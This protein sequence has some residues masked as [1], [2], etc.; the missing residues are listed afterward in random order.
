VLTP[1]GWDSAGD[2]YEIDAVAGVSNLQIDR[3]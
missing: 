3:V 1:P 2:R